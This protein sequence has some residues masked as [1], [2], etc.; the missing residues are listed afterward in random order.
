MVLKSVTT[1]G[2]RVDLEDLQ[3][4]KRLLDL[5]KYN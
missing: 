4:K 1:S 5:L 2:T 3:Q